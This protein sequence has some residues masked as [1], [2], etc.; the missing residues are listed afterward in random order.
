MIQNLET[1]I[2]ELGKR[3]DTLENSERFVPILYDVVLKY[4]EEVIRD[5]KRLEW[6]SQ[7]DGGLNAGY[8]YCLLGDF[9]K[10]IDLF[11][12]AI[13]VHEENHS[14]YGDSNEDVLNFVVG[15]LTESKAETN[16]LDHYKELLGSAVAEQ[17]EDCEEL[18]K[19]IVFLEADMECATDD[20]DAAYSRGRREQGLLYQKLGEFDKAIDHFEVAIKEDRRDWRNETSIKNTLSIVDSYYSLDENQSGANRFLGLMSNIFPEDFKEGDKLPEVFTDNFNKFKPYFKHP[21]LENNLEKIEEYVQA[22]LENLYSIVKPKTCKRESPDEHWKRREVA[23]LT[24]ILAGFY[25]EREEYGKADELYDKGREKLEYKH[26]LCFREQAE[27]AIRTGN[28]KKAK[29]LINRSKKEDKHH[30][31]GDNHIEE[32]VSLYLQLD[33]VD[34]ALKVYNDC[35]KKYKESLV[36]GSY[37]HIFDLRQDQI[38]IL[39]S[40]IGPDYVEQLRS[41]AKVWGE[42][43]IKE[44]KM[45]SFEEIINKNK[46]KNKKK[47]KRLVDDD[48]DDGDGFGWDDI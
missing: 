1:T 18:R 29:K 4:G 22:R 2:Q 47:K 34:S 20:I 25:I 35:C 7:Y 15:S 26:H 23:N 41:H 42:D 45:V 33:D 32:F 9:E 46:D 14:K 17:Y 27:F 38:S 19:K 44:Q 3:R 10:G 16:V 43:I 6:Q 31:P 39:K 36:S 11:D 21:E 24:E 37:G 8:I 12:W 40:V 13:K 48:G 28:P 30:G 5:L